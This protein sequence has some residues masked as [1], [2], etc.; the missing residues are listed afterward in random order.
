MKNLITV[1]FVSISVIAF[2]QSDCSG[3]L[4]SNET[5]NG[6][7]MN[8]SSECNSVTRNLIRFTPEKSI[9]GAFEKQLIQKIDGINANHPNQFKKKDYLENNL[10]EYNR[11]YFGYLNEDGEKVL[12]VN[13]FKEP[14]SC[15]MDSELIVLDGCH[16]YWR[17]SWIVKSDT[18]INFSVNGCA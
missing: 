14:I 4:I 11:Q 18:F 10:P 8:A 12:Y 16:G 2:G 15:E 9:I 6:V 17:I 7:I 1:I 5:Y 3:K 13:F